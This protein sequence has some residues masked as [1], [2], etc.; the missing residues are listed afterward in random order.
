MEV[1]LAPRLR[2]F[3]EF[4]AA[5]LS[6]MLSP[7][8]SSFSRL[9]KSGDSSFADALE[10]FEPRVVLDSLDLNFCGDSGLWK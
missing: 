10:P 8:P 7:I 5:A 1:K 9:S 2:P 6:H 4:L 3:A